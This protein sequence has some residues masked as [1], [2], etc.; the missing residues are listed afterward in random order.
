MCVEKVINLNLVLSEIVFEEITKDSESEFLREDILYIH[1]RG[2]AWNM[3]DWQKTESAKHGWRCQDRKA[4][5][6]HGYNYKFLEDR[7][8]EFKEVLDWMII[9]GK[10]MRMYKISKCDKNQKMFDSISY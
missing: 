10:K 4:L 6:E 9:L 3:K 8:K 2:K 5:M 1:R 7:M